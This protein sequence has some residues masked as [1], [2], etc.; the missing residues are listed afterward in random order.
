MISGII[1]EII[2]GNPTKEVASVPTAESE[3][4]YILTKPFPANKISRLKKKYKDKFTGQFREIEL[5][6]VGHADVTERLLEA[7]PHWNWQPMAVDQYGLPIFTKDA[8]GN[9]VGLWIRL[10][11]CGHQRLGYGSCE[12]GKADA[13][14]ELIGDA[15]RNAAMRFGVALAL[16]SKTREDDASFQEPAAAT[17]A[18]RRSSAK[19]RPVAEPE[20]T[21]PPILRPPREPG[22][23]DDFA[24]QVAEVFGGEP[25]PPFGKVERGPLKVLGVNVPKEHTLEHAENYVLTFGKHKGKTLG[26]L[27]RDAE[28]KSWIEWLAKKT[29]ADIRQGTKGKVYAS[30]YLV[31]LAYDSFQP[32]APIPGN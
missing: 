8:D 25:E 17:E 28:G 24:Q 29:A 11:V 16:W 4:L 14:K 22:E 10:E 19:P 3:G 18:P 7:D 26:D 15:I 1:L 12:Q 2:M 6:Y 5:D 32:T 30:D 9:P 13:V 31:L 20:P 27:L 21:S 23:D